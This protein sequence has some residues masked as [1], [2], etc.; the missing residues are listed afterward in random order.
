MNL[1]PKSLFKTTASRRLLA[2]L[3]LLAIAGLLNGCAGTARGKDTSVYSRQQAVTVEPRTRV[4]EVSAQVVIRYPAIIHAHAEPL[5]ISSFA[6]NAIGG[7]VPYAQYGKPHTARIAQS[8]IAKSGYY[9]M[10][11]YRELKERLPEGSVLLS[12]HLIVWDE[13][14]GLYSR[15]IIAS[16]EVPSVLTVDFNIYSF[17]D[18]SEM[19]DSPPVTFGDLVTPLLVVKSNRWVQPALGGL[20]IASEPLVDSSWRQARAGAAAQLQAR[21][22][23]QPE[24]WTP[25]LDFIAF[26]AERDGA[27][28]ALPMRTTGDRGAGSIAIEQY[29]VEK[30][31]LDKI[32]VSRLADDHS[33]DPFSRDFVRGA[34][35]RIIE[36]LNGIDHERATFFARQSALARF[37]PE[38]A[39]VFFLQSNDESVWARLQLAEALVAAERKYLAAQS[40]SIY[41]GTYEGDFGIKM[42]KIIAAEHRMLE[43]RRGLARKQ[44]ITA[45]VAA[46]ALA[47]SV[48][49]A[50]VSTTASSTMV[51]ALSG[52]SLMGSMW[53]M[54]RSMDARSESEEVNEYFIARMAPAFE[55]QMSVQME[56]LESKEVI[57]ARGFA[58]F[59]NKTL[60]LYQSRVRLL[61]VNADDRCEF[62]HPDLPGIGRW[63]GLC[64]QGLAQG[65]GYGLV[66]GPRGD[67]VEY[68]GEARR[69]LA[70][71]NGAMIRRFG[72]R[73]GDLYLEGSF[74]AG[75]PDGVVR[76]QAA[77]EPERL[78]EFRSG[79]D[80]GR[81]DPGQLRPFSFA[82]TGSSSAMLNP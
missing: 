80:V 66:V 74:S 13:E 4:D 1:Y 61:Q 81:G 48:Y 33:V 23:G 58:E 45:A 3:G 16:E 20:L 26:L 38:L 28:V 56:W 76:I 6:V 64:E 75:Q 18:A 39:D 42:R 67:A 17:P 31:Q 30:I 19:M 77:G 29:P 46:L 2:G 15:P 37:D 53:A 27:S 34:S 25:S 63:Y 41:S 69:G 11:L 70:E 71:G 57:T 65:R 10:S 32:L 59:R 52:V 5:F 12:P 40:D 62:R 43:E 51:A 54:N 68:V 72:G 36:L 9:A 7:E 60:S 21:L 47:G 49:G 50:T 8:V 35:D 78:R 22:D 24:N 14:R 73:P 44:N 82:A 55:R 79:R